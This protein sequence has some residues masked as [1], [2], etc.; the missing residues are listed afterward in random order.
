MNLSIYYHKQCMW[1]LIS[2]DNRLLITR[3]LMCRNQ[4][5]ILNNIFINMLFHLKSLN[6]LGLISTFI[7]SRYISDIQSHH[8]W[9]ILKY[10]FIRLNKHESYV[11]RKY[12]LHK[13]LLWRF[14]RC[15][16]ISCLIGVL[17]SCQ[18]EI[19]RNKKSS[20]LLLLL[21]V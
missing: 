7:S 17:R 5:S 12:L 13:L 18:M 14:I 11:M 4:H 8:Y 2:A 16:K 3:L 1:M 10:I 9:T 19:V 20:P 15:N 6:K 21:F